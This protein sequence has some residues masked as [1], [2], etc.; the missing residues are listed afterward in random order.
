MTRNT[1]ATSGRRRHPRRQLL[2]PRRR[3]QLD[4]EA[5]EVVVLVL[6][7]GVVQ[8]PAVGDIVLDRQ[9][10]P[11]QHR[12]IDRPCAVGTTFTARA[13][14]AATRARAAAS[15]PASIRSRLAST[16][17]SAQ[18]TWSPNTSSTGSSCSS[19][20]SAARCAAS[21]PRSAAT[22]PSASAGPSTTATT[23]RPSPAP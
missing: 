21:A 17:R 7:L 22:R 20:G 13:S 19:A 5:L 15:A 8:R 4:H 14:R 9:P 10:Q 1:F 11:E 18:A 6:A 23:R 2:R 3:R 16:I 12:R